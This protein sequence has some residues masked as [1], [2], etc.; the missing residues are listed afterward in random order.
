[1]N[2]SY[3][4]IL[5]NFF[6]KCVLTRQMY[7]NRYFFPY[8][9]NFTEL[10]HSL[11]SNINLFSS[12]SL[13]SASSLFANLTKFSYSR[14][15]EYSP[16]C[17]GLQAFP[18]LLCASS[19]LE[20]VTKLSFLLFFFFYWVRFRTNLESPAQKLSLRSYSTEKFTFISFR[21]KPIENSQA[22]LNVKSVKKIPVLV[23]RLFSLM[24]FT[25]VCF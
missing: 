16:A 13:A 24:L 7:Q 22:E 14:Y 1:M 2:P 17:K 10:Q 18:S 15:F 21:F 3:D 20:N 25:A 23:L 5:I 4:A 12:A 6:V 19:L 11:S 8:S 9:P